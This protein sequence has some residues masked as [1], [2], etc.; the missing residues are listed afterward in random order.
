VWVE[1]EM[2]CADGAGNEK[3]MIKIIKADTLTTIVHLLIPMSYPRA[4][5]RILGSHQNQKHANT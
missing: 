5:Y 3:P 4:L 1:V 2:I